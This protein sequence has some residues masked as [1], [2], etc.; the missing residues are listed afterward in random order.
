MTGRATHQIVGTD[1]LVP[2]SLY[3]R[4]RTELGIRRAAPIIEGFAWAGTRARHPKPRDRQ[5]GSPEDPAGM[6]A[7]GRPVRV[8]GIDP[9]A[10]AAFRD[11]FR[12]EAAAELD[13]ASFLRRPTALVSAA[14]ARDLGVGVGEPLVVAAGGRS[15]DLTIGVTFS[16]RD[17]FRRQAGRDLLILD[18]FHAQRIFGMGS[19]LTRIDLLLDGPDWDREQ[20][21]AAIREILPPGTEIARPES[22]T[23]AAGELTRAFRLNLR[24]LSLLGLLCGAFL[25]YNTMTFAVVQRRPILALLR[26]L[27][28]TP[29]RLFGVVLAEAAAVGFA[30]GCLGLAFGRLLAG[31]LLVRVEQTLDDL[32]FTTGSIWIE[33]PPW[34]TPAALLLA[35]AVALLA[36]L[37]PAVEALRAAPGPA[38]ARATLET[39]W[40]AALPKLTAAGGVLVTLGALAIW[41]QRG[42]LPTAFAA[43]FAILV[44][45][46][47][48]TPLATVGLSRLVAAPAE[49]TLGG[50]GRIAAAGVG[51]SISRTGVAVAALAV[52]ISVTLGVDLMIRSFRSTVDEWLL[53]S[54]PADLYVSST[55]S[56]RGAS[57]TAPPALRESDLDVLRTAPG[58]VRVN[59]VLETR[60]ESAVGA[61]RLL[62]HDLDARGRSAFRFRRARPEDAWPGYLAGTAVLISEPLASRHGLGPGDTLRLETPSGPVHPQVAAVFYDYASERGT[63]LMSWARYL[64]L[65]PEGRRRPGRTAA[66]L[67]LEPGSDPDAAR[68]G[69]ARRL[70]AGRSVPNRNLA[71]RS[72]GALRRRSLEVFDRTFLVTNVLRLLAVTVAF[73]GV[74]AALTALALERRRELAALRALGLTPKQLWG[75]VTCQSALLGLFAGLLALPMGAVTAALMTFVI[76]KRSFG[77]SMDLTLPVE[78]LAFALA[79]AVGSALLA[80]LYP[81]FRLARAPVA[82]ALRSD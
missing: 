35:V 81:A 78:S 26:A 5:A 65:W 43:L 58:V 45:L 14:T 21:L 9:F 2:E 46:A 76:N 31:R 53:Y 56:F 74:L 24:A 20:A 66:A 36:A 15:Q 29:K 16:S 68:T 4:L 6:P 77:W 71:V 23:A 30:G 38:L 18:V 72:N 52:A 13:L 59:T 12:N 54:L 34:L 8:L 63:V 25:I 40:R 79:L 44:G 48:T 62:A 22:R 70:E 41:S 11:A 42:G 17:A 39:R 51:A 55:A 50:L 47:L 28:V 7:N 33:P 60:V 49:R 69:V 10:D 57:G 61:V 73:I 67:Y 82:E 19:N 75:L 3:T 64:E 32:Y 27:G 80:G 1:A 37:G